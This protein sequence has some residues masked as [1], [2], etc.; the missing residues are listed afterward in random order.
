[1]PGIDGIELCRR[2]RERPRVAY[3]YIFLATGKNAKE[4]MVQGLEAGADDYLTKPFDQNEL[5]ARLQTGRRILTLQENLIR[6]GDE[7]RFQATHDTLTGIWNRG[8]VLDFLHRECA[9]AARTQSPTA[10]LMLDLDHFKMINDTH[11]HLAGDDVLREVAARISRQVRT[12][13]VVGRYGGE[14]FLIVLPGCPRNEIEAS[15][16]RI[17]TA[18]GN[19][20]IV[21]ASAELLVTA[22][23]GAAL[24]PADGAASE[25]QILLEVD[26]AL[27]LA[28][29]N[30]RNRVWLA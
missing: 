6:A 30:G 15:A 28:K 5:R 11:G 25:D 10:I 8:A 3:Q 26:Q 9:R 17:R 12:Y 18:I 23:I 21:T 19:K 27:Y 24:L 14:E 13:D 1:M 16:D 4:D 2:I 7:L 22:S 29:N 20:P